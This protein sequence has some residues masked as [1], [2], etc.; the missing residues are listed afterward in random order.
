MRKIAFVVA[1]AWW[2]V[3]RS[4]NNEMTWLLI[5]FGMPV[6][7]VIR[8]NKLHPNGADTFGT[9]HNFLVRDLGERHVEDVGNSDSGVFCWPCAV[10]TCGKR[11]ATVVGHTRDQIERAQ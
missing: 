2:T 11:H 3:M 1:V 10:G 7:Y 6:L 5:L 9:Y 8:F 4:G